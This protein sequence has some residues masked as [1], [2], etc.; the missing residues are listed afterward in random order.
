MVIKNWSYFS[1]RLFLLFFSPC[2]VKFYAKHT[3][4]MLKPAIQNSWKPQTSC[5]WSFFSFFFFFLQFSIHRQFSRRCVCV[6]VCLSE[7]REKLC[8]NWTV[9]VASFK[10]L[11]WSCAMKSEHMTIIKKMVIKLTY[12]PYIN[13][14]LQHIL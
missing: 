3:R 7:K 5:F 10:Y 2:A 9:T 14:S 12:L 4:E 11:S 1:K 6:C 8:A 13:Q